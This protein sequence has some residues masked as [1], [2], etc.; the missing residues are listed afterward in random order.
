M[1]RPTYLSL[2]R[3]LKYLIGE[4]G[5]T[6]A[7]ATTTGSTQKSHINASIN[8][9]CNR[10]PFSWN[11]A[12]S[13]ITLVAGVA[14]L[15]ADFNSK[16]GIEDARDSDGNIFTYINIPSRDLDDSA[17]MYWLSYDT[18]TDTYIFNS[19]QDSGTITVYYHFAPTALTVDASICVVPDEEAVSYLAAAKHWISDERN[20]EMATRFQREADARVSALYIQDLNF[21][22]AYGEGAPTQYETQLRGE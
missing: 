9:I 1:A 21:G 19:N 15:P 2:Q 13:D 20:E 16:W 3:R 5:S 14:T 8:D 6:G 17:K 22:P 10:N 7:D 4:D 11:V 12:H 18:S